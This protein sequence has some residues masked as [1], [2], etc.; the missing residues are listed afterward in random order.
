MDQTEVS[1]NSLVAH[2]AKDSV[3]SHFNTIQHF[4]TVLVE[5]TNK[6]YHQ[7]LDTLDDRPSPL[8]YVTERNISIVA[9]IVQM[10]HDIRDSLVDCWLM[11]EQFLTPV[12]GTAM[13][14]DRFFDVI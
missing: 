2:Q 9:V 3:A 8:P 1:I 11:I 6:Y 13:K 5:E 10:G 7:Y 12:Y 14:C 4:I